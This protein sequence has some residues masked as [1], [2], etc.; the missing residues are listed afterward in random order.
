ML[1]EDWRLQFQQPSLPFYFVLL[2]AYR[3]GDNQFP[4]VRQSQ[5]RALALPHTGAANAIDL[6]DEASPAGAVHSRNKSYVGER[7]ARWLLRD[8]YH[9]RVL[10]T[11]PRLTDAS[12]ITMMTTASRNVVVGTI[13]YGQGEENAE[14]HVMATPGCETCCMGG[15]G[16]LTAQVLNSTDRTVYS[17]VVTVSLDGRTLQFTV[18]LSTPLKA[19]AAELTLRFQWADYPECV[20]YNSELLPAEP[21]SFVVPVNATTS[22]A[23]AVRHSPPRAIVRSAKVARTRVAAGL[24]VSNFFSSNMILQRAPL[25]AKI[26]GTAAPAATVSLSLDGAEPLMAKAEASGYWLITLDPQRAGL[27]H[28]IVISSDGVSVNFTGVAFG[29]VYLCSG[30]SNMQINLNFSFGGAE[31]IEQYARY[32]NMRLFNMPQQSSDSPLNTTRITFPQG[33][34]PPSPA[35]LAC[36]AGCLWNQFSAVCWYAGRDVYD[37]LNGSVPIGLLHGSYGGTVVEAWTSPTLNSRCGPIPANPPGSNP[38]GQNNASACYNAMI[39]PMLP[40]TFSA[41][42][43]YQ[44]SRAL[45]VLHAQLPPSFPQH[46]LIDSPLCCCPVSQARAIG[47]THS[48]PPT[49]SALHPTSL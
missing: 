45:T 18:P 27:G 21:W 20:L 5:L 22:S 28:T 6:G 34:L 38:V 43:W 42:L 16:L 35:S 33:W 9:E 49:A 46:T 17:P 47:P 14:L 19:V 26:W 15:A 41:V 48:A 10:V 32:P 36:G 40:M 8:V 11:G 37:R 1:I 24:T 29:D 30:Q 31:A 25:S 4:T 13:R 39:Y 12:G 23:V 2:N 3:G 7:L 44:G